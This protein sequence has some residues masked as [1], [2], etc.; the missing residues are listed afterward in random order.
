MS[1]PIIDNQMM[2][3]I[4]DRIVRRSD[5]DKIIL[6]GSRARGAARPDSDMDL[7]VIADSDLPRSRRAV[8][9][10]DALSDMPIAMDIVVYR[11]SE[12]QDWSQVAEAFITTAVREGTVLYENHG[13]PRRWVA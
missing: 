10:Y 12:V 3:D 2:S 7:L 8:P 5:P 9:L 13:R 6:F 11:S 4:V 1:T